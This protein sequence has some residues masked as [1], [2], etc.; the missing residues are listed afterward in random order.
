MN[1]GR[2]P[3]TPTVHSARTEDLDAT[4]R[5]AIVEVCVAAHQEEGFRNLLSY[6]QSG[7]WQVIAYWE[8]QLA[9]HA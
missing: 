7:S 4:R 9:S 3:M 2:L 8:G 6:V 1:E 5:A